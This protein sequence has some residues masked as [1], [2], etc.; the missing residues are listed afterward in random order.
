MTAQSD[1]FLSYNREDAETAKRFA[2]AFSAEGLR[3]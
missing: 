2:D 1:I 3:V